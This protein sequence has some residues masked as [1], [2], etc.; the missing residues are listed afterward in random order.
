MKTDYRQILKKCKVGYP[1]GNTHD[2]DIVKSNYLTTMLCFV[3]M[4]F[5]IK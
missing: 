3:P 5:I 1:G 2:D 4:Y